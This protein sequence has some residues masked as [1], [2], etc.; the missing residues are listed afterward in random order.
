MTITKTHEPNL[1]GSIR[2]TGNHESRLLPV[3]VRNPGIGPLCTQHSSN[4]ASGLTKDD[5]FTFLMWLT[6]DDVFTF[7]C[8]RLS[9]LVNQGPFSAPVHGIWQHSGSRVRAIQG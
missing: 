6:K 1:K 9:A 8:A 7:L 2:T 4:D 3:F 5:A